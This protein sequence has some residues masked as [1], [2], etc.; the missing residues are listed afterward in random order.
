MAQEFSGFFDSTQ[1]TE[2]TYSAAELATAFRALGGTGA[3]SLADGLR[4]RAE[5]GTMRTIVEPGLAMVRGYTYELRD[6]G[7]PQLAITHVVSAASE[8]IDR[9]ALQLN[10]I[11]DGEIRLK[12]LTGTPAANPQPPALTRTGM[13]Y[14]ISLARIHVRAGAAEISQGDVVD[15]RA[16]ESVCGVLAPEGLRLDALFARMAKTQ[17]TANAPGLMAAADKVYLETLK[18]A[19]TAAGDSVNLG[20][21]Y[22]DNALF[23]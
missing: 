4:V 13:I 19:I 16:D 21:K 3:E 23:R 5:G 12:L 22:L 9:I 1:T 14:E 2:R 17:A 8:R 15:E 10:L 6:D 11:E 20:G 7:G 18:G